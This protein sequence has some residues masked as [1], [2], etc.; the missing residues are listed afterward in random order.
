MPHYC[1]LFAIV[2]MILAAVSGCE[3]GSAGET[4]QD[5]SPSATPISDTYTQQPGSAPSGFPAEPAVP[6]PTEAVL[7]AVGDIMMHTP[8]LPGSYDAKTGKY[9]FDGYFRHVAPIISEGDWAIANLE[10][11][12]AGANRG[13]KG[14]PLFNAP[15]ELAAALKNAGFNIVT[16]ANNHA[17]D[18][19]AAGVLATLQTVRAHGLEP[20]GTFADAESAGKALV[21]EKSGIVNA[22]LSYTYG[23]NGIPI[24]ED[25]PF[26]VS[27]IDKER[28]KE[29]I[30]VARSEGA[31]FVTVALH[32]GNEY[33]RQP[34]E[35][36]LDLAEHCIKAGAD[37][38]L[39]SHPHVVQPY[40]RI[41]TTGYD[42]SKRS[43]I[44]IYSMGNF[45]SNQFGNYKE[46]GVI[47]KIRIKKTYSDSGESET[48]I[49]DVEPIPT[50]VHKYKSGGK[51]MYR[52]LPLETITAELNDPLIPN[53]LIP[54]LEQRAAEMN[55]HLES[56]TVQAQSEA[57]Q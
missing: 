31:D 46:F 13:Y 15:D 28:M 19:G 49:T 23:T 16:T 11:P 35:T 42:G 36:Q 7:T 10:T 30:A 44:A 18:Q 34:N 22:I 2:L 3:R 41:R 55:A 40:E 32:F 54:L 24:P 50:W 20:I 38:V 6:P 4:N 29:Q 26:L 48:E 27:L 17:L 25:K 14:Y 37:L 57:S 5:K 21:M 56:L 39:G 51:A 53:R 12:I 52:V 8:Q 9:N 33:Q 1:R 47:F 45:I 43:G